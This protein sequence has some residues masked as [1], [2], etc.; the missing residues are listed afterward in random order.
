MNKMRRVIGR[1]AIVLIVGLLLLPTSGFSAQPVISCSGFISDEDVRR[2]GWI[3]FHDGRVLRI[4]LAQG[5]LAVDL[6]GKH[7]GIYLNAE[8]QICRGDKSGT[9]K[10]I[11]VGERVGGFTKIIQGRSV[12]MEL[13]FGP[14]NPYPVGIPHFG[15]VGYVF[16]PYALDKPAF[17]VHRN[18][19]PGALIKCPYTGKMFRNPPP[20]PKWTIVFAAQA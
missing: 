8:T 14:R 11:Q 5:L 7:Y 18:V 3:S 9:I 15:S 13:G 20:P 4:D 16:S 19:A 6:D 1:E 12:A 2:N 17:K 10:Q